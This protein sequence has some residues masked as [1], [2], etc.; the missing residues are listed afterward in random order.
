MGLVFW[1]E[2]EWSNNSEKLKSGEE[3][4]AKYCGEPGCSCEP[5]FV[6]LLSCRDEVSVRRSR[7]LLIVDYIL[8]IEV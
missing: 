4:L 1:L 6:L 8:L 7:R 3:L 5:L 2:V